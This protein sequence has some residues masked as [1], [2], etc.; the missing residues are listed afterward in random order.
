LV[1][2]LTEES[3]TH[4]DWLNGDIGTLREDYARARAKPV[5][6]DAVWY[7]IG[8]NTHAVGVLCFPGD[9]EAKTAI[10][11]FHGGG[12][13]VG[14]PVT[15][16]DI[17]A[18]L[19]RHTGLPVHSIDYR[20]APDHQAPAPA[21]D[22]I[23]VIRQLIETGID[24]LVICGDSAGGAIALATETSLPD[25]LRNHIIGVAS[26]YGA[27]GLLDTESIRTRGNRADGTDRDCVKRYFDLA[28]RDAYSIETLVKPSPV[29]VYLI[30]AEDDALRDDTLALAQA[31]TSQGRDVSL[32]RV[33][34][35]DHG[36]LHGGEGS[37][38]AEAALTRFAAW[39]AARQIQ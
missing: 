12:F 34:C 36:F 28:G 31:L 24:N 21:E 23:A 32:D 20:L 13:I 16:A 14:S 1:V 3:A 27:H 10:V 9:G 26:F 33:P 18:R 15:H 37:A 17:A 29:P 6:P 7:R 11:Y 25:N 2:R 8:A 30:A 35:V 19:A 5:P 38:A 4:F 39:F 22:G